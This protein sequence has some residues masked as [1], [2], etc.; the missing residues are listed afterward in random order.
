MQLSL[1]FLSFFFQS[2]N[3]AQYVGNKW[4]ITIVEIDHNLD[5]FHCLQQ[6][7]PMGFFH[8]YNSQLLCRVVMSFF[9]KQFFSIFPF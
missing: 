1:F 8:F 9:T 4:S 2:K 7:M 5:Y 3:E 6:K